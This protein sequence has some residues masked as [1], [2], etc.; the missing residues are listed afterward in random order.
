MNIAIR[1]FSK[2]G[3]TEKMVGVIRELTGVKPETVAVP[4]TE[5]VDTLY[6]G[7]GVMLGKVNSAVVD[8]IKTLKPEQVKKVICFGSCA[9]IKSPVPQMRQLLEAQGI[10]V[11]SEEF[12]CRGS[13]GPL[14][15]GH[16]NQ[17]DLEDFRLFIAKQNV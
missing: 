5:P 2:F 14:H 13:M 6:L 3:H 16:P 17:A 8:F 15:A 4:L 1:Y 9:I 11:S 10:T 7:S 12:T